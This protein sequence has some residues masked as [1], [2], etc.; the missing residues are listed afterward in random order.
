MKLA[1]DSLSSRIGTG[2]AEVFVTV[3]NRFDTARTAFGA[4]SSSANATTTMAAIPNTILRS[5]F[6]FFLQFGRIAR[7]GEGE[8]VREQSQRNSF[9]N[10]L[11][12]LR[13][14]Y[15]DTYREI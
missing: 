12:Q 1:R 9:Q 7:N 6:M 3:M 15:G 2:L 8:G 4:T 14:V 13:F 5:T 10:L 11:K